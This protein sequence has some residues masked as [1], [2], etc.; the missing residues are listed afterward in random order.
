MRFTIP[1]SLY[2]VGLC[3]RGVGWYVSLII[4]LS[5]LGINHRYLLCHSYTHVGRIIVMITTV[6]QITLCNEIEV[7]QA[8][9]RHLSSTIEYLNLLNVKNKHKRHNTRRHIIIGSTEYELFILLALILRV[10]FH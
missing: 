7:L 6:V 1:T 3:V 4:V 9:D 5:L 10:V 2:R 8:N